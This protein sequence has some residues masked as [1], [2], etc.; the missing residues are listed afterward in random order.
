[1]AE[2]RT[3]L[4]YLFRLKHVTGFITDSEVLCVRVYHP[5]LVGE[6]EGIV[7]VLHIQFAILSCS[8]SGLSFEQS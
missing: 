3:Y 8:M 7:S 6:K 4:L 5:V 2:Y 1:M